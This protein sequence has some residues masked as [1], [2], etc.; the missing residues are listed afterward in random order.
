MQIKKE[1]LAKITINSRG[2]N[3]QAEEEQYV[4]ISKTK[5]FKPVLKSKPIITTTPFSGQFLRNTSG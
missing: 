3:I 5:K 2:N 4:N 1:D